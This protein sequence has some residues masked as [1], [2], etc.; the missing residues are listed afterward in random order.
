MFWQRSGRVV[1]VFFLL[2][3][4]VPFQASLPVAAGT[5]TVTG[6]GD[7]VANDGVCTLREAITSANTNTSIDTSDIRA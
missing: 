1:V 2:C 5:L 6:A 4:A 7:T 3:L